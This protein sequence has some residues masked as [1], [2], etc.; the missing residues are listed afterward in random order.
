MAYKAVIWLVCLPNRE[1]SGG[2]SFHYDKSK[3]TG[4]IV[5]SSS[6][7]ALW[8]WWQA[9]D[10]QIKILLAWG[11]SPQLAPPPS[12]PQNHSRP[13]DSGHPSGPEEWS[14]CSQTQKSICLDSPQQ[15]GDAYLFWKEKDHTVQLVTLLAAVQQTSIA[16]LDC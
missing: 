7:A 3:T 5:T 9:P 6:R 13:R 10:S 2:Q 1:H 4:A 11:F 14:Q 12:T 16:S 8:G 15:F